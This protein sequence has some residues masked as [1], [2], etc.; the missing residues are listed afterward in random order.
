MVFGLLQLLLVLGQRVDFL[1][2]ALN[3]QF[4]LLLAADVVSALGFELPEELLVFSVG[5]R[6]RSLTL[7]LLLL[8]LRYFR[9]RWRPNQL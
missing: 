8:A 2:K 9:P 5:R 4:H 3:V 1:L 7:R 6:D